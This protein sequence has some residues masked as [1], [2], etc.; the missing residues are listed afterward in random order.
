MNLLRHHLGIIRGARAH[1]VGVGGEED[2]S[3]R[4]ASFT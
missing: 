2:N 3:E 4:A 1:G